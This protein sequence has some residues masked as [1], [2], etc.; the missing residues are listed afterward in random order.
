MERPRKRN[1]AALDDLVNDL[2]ADIFG[3]QARSSDNWVI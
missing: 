1:S 3:E 2:K